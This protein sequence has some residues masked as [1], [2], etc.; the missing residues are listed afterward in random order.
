MVV[1]PASGLSFSGFFSCFMHPLRFAKGHRILSIHLLV[2]SMD[3]KSHG[4]IYY[5]NSRMIRISF[6]YLESTWRLG[7]PLSKYLDVPGG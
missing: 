2:D 4:R 1:F 6:I 7:P 5:L 3:I